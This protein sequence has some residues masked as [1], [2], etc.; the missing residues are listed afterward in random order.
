MC[1]PAAS[2]VAS[3]R[4]AA[5]LTPCRLHLGHFNPSST[6]SHLIYCY[7]LL[8]ALWF[9]CSPSISFPQAYQGSWWR[10]CQIAS[11]LCSRPSVLPISL[12][13]QRP[14]KGLHG[15]AWSASSPSCLPLTYQAHFHPRA[16]VPAVRAVKKGSRPWGKN[17]GI[18]T[19]V[20]LLKY[21]YRV[22]LP[23]L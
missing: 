23:R 19:E 17:W 14:C 6:L 1:N 2:N 15:P 9:H 4:H 22:F 21:F 13:S 7:S 12:R 20:E 3:P 10:I 16:F 8:P 18:L 11:C 5:H